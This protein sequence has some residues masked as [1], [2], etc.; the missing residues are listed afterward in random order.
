LAASA[1]PDGPW[2]MSDPRRDHTTIPYTDADTEAL[3]DELVDT[4]I[5]FRCPMGLGDAG[6]T[7]S[8]LASLEAEIAF[9]L[10]EAV[11]DARDQSYT[12]NEIAMRLAI[13][14]SA[15]RHR[16]AAYAQSRRERL[17]EPASVATSDTHA[18]DV[19]PAIA[20]R[21]TPS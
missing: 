1:V 3:V 8:V 21:E 9:R 7:V 2:D 17:H 13:T 12:W 15:A 10:P 16:Y 14:V 18:S 4:L 19:G 11:A 6:A 5:I 20:G